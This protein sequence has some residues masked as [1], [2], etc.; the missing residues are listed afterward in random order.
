MFAI[1][2][3]GRLDEQQNRVRPRRMSRFTPHR[4]G[5]PLKQT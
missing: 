5:M 3:E 1:D 4:A 2:P